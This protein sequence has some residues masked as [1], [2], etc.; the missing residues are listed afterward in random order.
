MNLNL[1]LTQKIIEFAKSEGILRNQL[2]HILAEA[3]HE[4]AHTMQPVKEAFWVK[5]KDLEAWR[6]KNLRY[7]PWY[8]RGLV[9]ITWEENYKDAGKKL[10]IDL[11]TDPDKVMEP[12]VAIKILVLGIR[13]GWFTNGKYH[14]VDF[15]NL[16][17][18]DFKEARRLVNGTDDAELIADLSRQY[19]ADLLKIGYGVD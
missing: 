5:S 14:L 19:D 2:A 3:Y 18:S 9:Q 6:K 11:T 1:G 12:D 4:S 16:K 17:K 10:G 15:V 8:G 13:D 7:Y